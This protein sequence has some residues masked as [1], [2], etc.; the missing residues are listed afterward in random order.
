[1]LAPTKKSDV[2][3]HHVRSDFA[4]EPK[5]RRS[6]THQPIA[7]TAPPEADE[8]PLE[9]DETI[10]PVF[11]G[12]DRQ[13]T[14]TRQGDLKF[15]GERSKRGEVTLGICSVSI[16]PMHRLGKLERPAWW[17]FWTSARRGEHVVLL[18]TTSLGAATFFKELKKAVHQPKSAFV[19]IH[20]YNVAFDTAAM[21]TA[22]L[23]LDLQFPGAPIMFSWPSKGGVANYPSDE[24][25][26]EWARPHLKQFLNQLRNRAD[27]DQIHLIAH[28]MGSR[29][30]LSVLQELS[31]GPKFEQ[32]ILAAPD[33]D[34]GI[35]RQLALQL[36]ALSNRVT[37]Y[38]SSTDKALALS[39]RIHEYAR[40]GEAGENIL[41]LKGLDTIDASTVD[42]DFLGHSTFA[43]ERTLLTDIFNLITH[44]HE[45]ASRFGL[46]RKP[47]NGGYYWSFRS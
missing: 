45:P 47:H 40:A 21:R 29:A 5:L 16:P 19:F 18:S 25:S 11:F 1:M 31:G 17:K 23:A 12:T 44:G 7:R 46:T 27:A 43:Q 13:A 8:P 9:L 34:A 4:P 28:S 42:T 39:K 10:I 35:F 15:S 36:P 24:G 6:E 14:E 2:Q 30:L 20:G 26:N 37:L 3:I 22:Q 33:V 38:A 32:L 41:V